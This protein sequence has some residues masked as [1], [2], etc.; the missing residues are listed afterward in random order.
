MPVVLFDIDGTLVHTDGA[1]RIALLAALTDEFG[2]TSPQRV[3]VVGCTDRGIARDLFL[4]HGLEDTEE[5]ARRLRV[6]YLERLRG[7]LPRRRGRVLPGV[8]E[9]LKQLGLRSDATLGLLTGN[10]REAARLKLDYYQLGSHFAFG[11]FGDRH[12]DRDDV[13][14]EALLQLTKRFGRMTDG[15]R[16]WVVGDTPLDIRCARAISAMAVAVATGEHTRED[17]QAVGPDLLLDSLEDAA[18]LL[19]LLG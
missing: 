19:H 18:P 11:A 8:K 3:P 15:Q 14:R 1:G 10:V 5:N 4:A 9:L 6:A 16:I 12:V 17:L 7:E 2:I 13:A